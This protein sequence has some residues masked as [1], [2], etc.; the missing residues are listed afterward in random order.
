M[1]I[2]LHELK[3]LRR[4]TIVWTCAII[5]LAA[6]YF[7]F[8][9][10]VV[11]DAGDFKKLMSGYPAPIRAALGIS[12]DNVTSVLGYYTMVFAFVPL[13]GAI[14]SMIF[15]MS[16]LSRETRERTADFLM[17]KP[18]SRTAIVSAKLLAAVTMLIGTNT[19]YDAAAFFLAFIVK[20]SDFS[21]RVLF[22]INLTLLFIQ[23][24]FLALGL[25]ISVFFKKLRSVLPVSLGVVLGLYMLGA[26][27]VTGKDADVVRFFFPFKY[28]DIAY[29]TKHAGYEMPYLITGAV[30]V[31]AAVAAAYLIYAKKDIHAV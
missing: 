23:L 15:G 27:A 13:C 16:V 25:F 10:G 1:N 5:A 2:Y 29:V 6:L 30:V 24:V 11:H 18:V 8:Y 4:S 14:Q 28:F 22:L 20:T 31:L 9:P 12:L 3:T 19:L 17:V 7:S 21:G 26:L